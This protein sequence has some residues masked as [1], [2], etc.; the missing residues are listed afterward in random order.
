MFMAE[1][2]GGDDDDDHGEHETANPRRAAEGGAGGAQVDQAP[3]ALP[4]LCP[5]GERARGT[6]EQLAELLTANG[7]TAPAKWGD[8]DEAT[9][10]RVL[11][12]LT[13]KLRDGRE[14]HGGGGGGSAVNGALGAAPRSTRPSQ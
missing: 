9:L 7:V 6:K 11:A 3:A 1:G 10:V 14:L 2:E 8:L 13:A 12:I 4:R 5:S